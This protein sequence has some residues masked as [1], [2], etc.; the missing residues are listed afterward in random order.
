MSPARSSWDGQRAV[1]HAEAAVDRD[2][3]AVDV[4]GGVAG[5]P[6]HH[7]GDLVG[8][9]IRPAGIALRISALRSSVRAAVM[10]V[11]MNPGATT[12]AVMLRVP[13]SRVIDRASPTRPALLAA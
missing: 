11:S 3:R 7:G 12:L 5:Q 8:V 9:A 10:S 13:S 6:G 2:D 1:P 4:A